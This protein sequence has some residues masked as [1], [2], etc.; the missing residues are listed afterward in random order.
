MQFLYVFTQKMNNNVA[1]R[2]LDYMVGG[3]TGDVSKLTPDQIVHTYKSRHC[4][5]A[6]CEIRML[7]V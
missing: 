1:P 4:K 2:N 5:N 3:A 7:S 6:L